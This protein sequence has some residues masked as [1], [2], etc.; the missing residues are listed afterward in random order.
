MDS[1][2]RTDELL[3][4]ARLEL[5]RDGHVALPDCIHPTARER[6]ISSLG[7][8]QLLMPEAVE[9][10]EPNRFA[11]EFDDYLA[12]LID[13]PQLLAL[14]RQVLGSEIRFDHCVTLNRPGGNAGSRWH[15]HSYGEECPDF[16]FLRV[17][18]YVNGF[19]ADDGAL[20]VIRGS[21]HYRDPQIKADSD[22]EITSGWMVGKIHPETGE[23]LR[24]EELTAPSGSVV[25]MWT[26]AAHAV[27]PRK[28]ASDTRWTVV[29]AYRN[30]GEP[31][32]ARWITEE[33][34]A[35]AS[36]GPGLM[37]LY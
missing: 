18:F 31:S 19:T 16:G 5:D 13:H 12:S 2:L 3:E 25:L 8:I 14:C 24:I 17:F 4:A 22:E 9:G 6:L 36:A 33:F 21:H 20:K 15:S 1:L 34:E 29:Y 27:T 30:P 23:P 35:N 37:S 7:H 26:H 32:H 11:A 28:E 10:H